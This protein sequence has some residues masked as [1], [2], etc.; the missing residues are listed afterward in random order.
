MEVQK[1]KTKLYA[2]K[3]KKCFKNKDT[4]RLKIKGCKNVPY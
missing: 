3:K 2:T 4:N 1:S